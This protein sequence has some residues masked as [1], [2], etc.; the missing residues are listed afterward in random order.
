MNWA[1]IELKSSG[2]STPSFLAQYSGLVRVEDVQLVY[3]DQRGKGFSQE[4]NQA[5]VVATI[6]PLQPVRVKAEGSA[7]TESAPGK[8]SLVGQFEPLHPSLEARIEYSKLSASNISKHP[9]IPLLLDIPQGTISGTVWLDGRQE[10]WAN[11]WKDLTYRL[12]LKLAG[13]AVA[14]DLEACKTLAGFLPDLVDASKHAKPVKPELKASV[15]H[16]LLQSTNVSG[17]I[18][19]GS[20]LFKLENLVGSILGGKAYVSGSI[21]SSSHTSNDRVAFRVEKADLSRVN[22]QGGPK[23]KGQLTIDGQFNGP[24]AHPE[25]LADVR[26]PE[27]TVLGRSFQNLRTSFQWTDHSLKIDRF[28]ASSKGSKVEMDGWI[29]AKADPQFALHLKTDNADLREFVPSLKGSVR[30]DGQFSLLG[31][32]KN[33][34][35]S[36]TAQVHGLSNLGLPTE[37]AQSRLIADRSGAILFDVQGDGA[38]SGVKVPWATYDFAQQYATAGVQATGYPVPGGS[39]SASLQVRGNLQNRDSWVATGRVTEGS[40]AFQGQ[41]LSGLRGDF[42]FANGIA[43]TSGMA[44]NW[45]QGQLNLVGQL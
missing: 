19:Y 45:G 32:L 39:V 11:L 22:M 9:L 16:T 37:S 24:L 27:V 2:T 18:R 7:P 29:F 21:A 8:V 5:T 34:V 35:V 43:Q 25:V 38:L 36:G 44:A 15:L 31:S 30:A 1:K 14:P 6:R 26:S 23:L 41:S 33:P 28:T 3:L 17:R 20:G 13:V 42:F 4:I 10:R 12:D 40:A